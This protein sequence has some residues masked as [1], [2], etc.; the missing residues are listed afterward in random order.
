MKGIILAGGY[1]TRMY[2]ITKSVSKQLLCIYDKPMI[3]YPLATLLSAGITEILIISTPQDLPCYIKLFGS[4]NKLGIKISY[5]EQ[6][7]PEGL[8][9]AFIIA[10]DFI[11]S[12]NVCMVLGDNIFHGNG[13]NE[14]LINAVNNVQKTKKATVFGY[15]VN[16]PERYG[17]LGFDKFEK[18][19]SINEKPLNPKSH[20]AVIGL[21]FYPNCVVKMAKN[22]KPSKRGELEITSINN[23][24]LSDN[25]LNVE[26]LGSGYTWLD[27]GTPDSLLE[28]SNFIQTIEKRQ[29]KKFSCIEEIAY[30]MGYINSKQLNTIGQSLS[31][32]EYGKY[33]LNINE[34]EF[35]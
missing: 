1:G 19:I 12:D 22:V 18:V 6:L 13:F 31:N 3:Y 20:Y 2:P 27:T 11:G 4:G 14:I 15:Y 8:A 7:K 21:Y 35:N 16:N 17:V 5:L 26:I 9:Q 25:R 33:L 24:Y 34:G 32:S 10:E 30:K 23:L 28:A 29:G